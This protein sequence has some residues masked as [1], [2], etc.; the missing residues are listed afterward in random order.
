MKT[1]DRVYY[2]GVI[3]SLIALCTKHIG[4]SAVMLSVGIIMVLVGYM[5]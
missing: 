4:I 1:R 5:K 2:L 3:L